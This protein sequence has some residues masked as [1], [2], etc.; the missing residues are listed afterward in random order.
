MRRLATL[1]AASL[2]ATVAA[3][4]VAAQT[5]TAPG[6]I[7]SPACVTQR[8]LADYDVMDIGTITPNSAV[9]E[10][11]AFNNLYGA[12]GG[13]GDGA[14]SEFSIV[15]SIHN[16]KT[17]SRLVRAGVR[18]VNSGSPNLFT[19]GYTRSGLSPNTLYY[20]S[21]SVFNST[22]L[23]R[24]CFMTGGTYTITNQ[25][26]DI[27]HNGSNGCF[28]IS[29][30]TYQDVRNCLCGR[31]NTGTVGATNYDYTSIRPSLGCADQ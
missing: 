24:R 30:R 21:V 10:V 13:G 1:L 18:T 28:T 11:K 15:Y 19:N 14:P 23:A 9:I 29:P 5:I 4:P 2:A 6:L 27:A 26:T 25:S 31:G 22:V 12:L 16:A 8:E 17:G 3:A 7:G 20:A